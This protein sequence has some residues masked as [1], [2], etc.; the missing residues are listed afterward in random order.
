V[1]AG[2]ARPGQVRLNPEEE[3]TGAE[4]ARRRAWAGQ[5]R[6]ERSPGSSDDQ[7]REP[8]DAAPD[9][10]PGGVSELRAY[11]GDPTGVVQAVRKAASDQVGFL[12]VARA[13]DRVV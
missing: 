13:A 7:Y 6:G 4:R 1:A 9:D 3:L 12:W 2:E 10:A 11:P 5:P 8:P